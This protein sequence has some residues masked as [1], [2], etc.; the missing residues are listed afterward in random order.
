MHAAPYAAD[1]ARCTE[2][3]QPAPP[4]AWSEALK[5][6]KPRMLLQIVERLR[7]DGGLDAPVVGVF[8]DR[9]VGA[10]SVGA[11]DPSAQY[12]AVGH[13]SHPVCPRSD[14]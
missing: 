6:L 2:F 13:R 7:T 1:I 10:P 3:G 14:W 8:L 9:V 4:E 12:D 5:R 11:L